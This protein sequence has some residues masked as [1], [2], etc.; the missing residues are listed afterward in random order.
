VQIAKIMGMRPIVIDGG[1]RKAQLAKEMGAE[2]YIDFTKVKDVAAEVKRIT[3]GIGAH[4]CVVTAYQAYKGRSMAVG[5]SS[6]S[7]ESNRQR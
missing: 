1:D 2:E 7:N 4:G 5:F 6:D 3:D